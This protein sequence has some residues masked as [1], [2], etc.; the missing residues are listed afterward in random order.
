MV[1][2][3]K[4]ALRCKQGFPLI[5]HGDLVF[6]PKTQFLIRPENFLS[7][8][9]DDNFKNCYLYSVNKGFP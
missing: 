8:I 7:K 6:D 3:P 4:S 2:T 1:L 9:H 5:L